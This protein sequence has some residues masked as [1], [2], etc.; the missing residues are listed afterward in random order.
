M[1]MNETLAKSSGINETHIG[2]VTDIVDGLVT[3]S[4][5]TRLANVQMINGFGITSPPVIG[6]E[7]LVLSTKTGEYVCVGD[8]SRTVLGE[9]DETVISSGGGGSIT[10]KS[11]GS[12]LINGLTITPSGQMIPAAAV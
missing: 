4:S 2:I 3:I 11:D 8:A 7:V 6:Q 12:V 1:W 5:H 9:G 10:L